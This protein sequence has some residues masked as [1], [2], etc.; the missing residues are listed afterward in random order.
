VIVV[1]L[2]SSVSIL[3][4]DAIMSLPRALAKLTKPRISSAV[5]TL[6]ELIRGAPY[7]TL[8]LI[9]ATAGGLGTYAV[10][11]AGGDLLLS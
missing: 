5:S 3:L 2:N 4:I 1:R 10:F 9:S 7:Q 6:R 8:S 11:M